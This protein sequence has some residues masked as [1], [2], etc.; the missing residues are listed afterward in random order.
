MPAIMGLMDY[1]RLEDN[2]RYEQGMPAIMGL[3]DGQGAM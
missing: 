2:T 3:M 1:K